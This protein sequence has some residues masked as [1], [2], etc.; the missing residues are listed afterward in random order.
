MT[1]ITMPRELDSAIQQ[2]SDQ[3][4]ASCV[5]A[6]AERYGFDPEEAHRFLAETSGVKLVKK[7]GPAPKPKA[8]KAAKAAKGS[9]DETEKPKRRPTGYLLFSAEE[10]PEVK[11]ELTEAL[12]PETKLAPQAVVKALAARWKALEQEERDSWNEMAKEELVIEEA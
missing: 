3:A 5:V 10:R 6:L 4:K 1:T 12:E 8:P 7:R 2:I 11:A 9:G